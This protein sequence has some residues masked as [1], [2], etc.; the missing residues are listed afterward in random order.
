MHTMLFLQNTSRM[1][2]AHYPRDS[3]ILVILFYWDTLVTNK[4]TMFCW[5][6]AHKKLLYKIFKAFPFQHQIVIVYYSEWVTVAT[7]KAAILLEF[8]MCKKGW[9]QCKLSRIG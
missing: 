3:F 6:M 4:Q 8:P 1:S 7:H 9:R 2:C 5:Y